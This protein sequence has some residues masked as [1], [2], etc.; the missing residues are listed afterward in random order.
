MLIPMAIELGEGQ[1]RRSAWSKIDHA[2][3]SGYTSSTRAASED[4]SACRADE[5]QLHPSQQHIYHALTY[6]RQPVD[7][8]SGLLKRQ[9]PWILWEGLII[10][11]PLDGQSTPCS[12]RD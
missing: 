5:P 12:N 1:G 3:C 8:Y 4:P 9:G 6:H 11:A 10:E 2:P 7:R